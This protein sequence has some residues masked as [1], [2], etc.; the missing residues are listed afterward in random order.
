[1]CIR[2]IVN[3]LS[4]LHGSNLTLKQS[5]NRCCKSM[6]SAMIPTFLR[7]ASGSRHSVKYL[8]RKKIFTVGH[9]HSCR[10][11]YR[12][13]NTVCLQH[14]IFGWFRMSSMV[15][16]ILV[17]YLN[18]SK[19]SACSVCTTQSFFFKNVLVACTVG[20]SKSKKFLKLNS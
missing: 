12:L 17:R 6:L 8:C 18:E 10:I 4:A 2:T 9:P 1:M 13:R 19:T 15:M 11:S 7:D 16:P 14:K 20:N 3:E 5:A